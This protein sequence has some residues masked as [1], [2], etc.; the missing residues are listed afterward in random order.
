[1]VLDLATGQAIGLHFSG[2]YMRGNFAVP[3]KV[4]DKLVD[5]RPW[6]GVIFASELT[7]QEGLNERKGS[8]KAR[9]RREDYP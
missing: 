1:V 6:K 2:V 3:S 9:S 4:V 7:R 5:Q 8:F